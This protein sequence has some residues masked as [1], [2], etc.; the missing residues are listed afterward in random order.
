MFL[1]RFFCPIN[2]KIWYFWKTCCLDFNLIIPHGPISYDHERKILTFFFV[3]SFNNIFFRV[4]H[5]LIKKPTNDEFQFLDKNVIPTHLFVPKFQ[6]IDF[7][8]KKNS[9]WNK[10]T[11]FSNIIFKNTHFLPKKLRFISSIELYAK[12]FC[13]S[14]KKNA[15]HRKLFWIQ[16]S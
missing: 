2:N 13:Q 12:L 3:G 9:L 8:P 10:R 4:N 15:I 7:C 5:F 16:I 6:F 14:T 11:F 1:V